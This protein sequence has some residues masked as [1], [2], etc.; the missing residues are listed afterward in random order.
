MPEPVVELQ[1]ENH[2]ARITLNRPEVHNAVDVRV[3][4]T[5]EANLEVIEADESV[6]AIILSGGGSTTFCAGGDL[7]YFATLNTREAC[8]EM[9]RRMQSILERLFYGGRPVI[10]AVNGNALGGGCEILTACHIRIAAAHA[11]FSF[12]QAPNGIITGWGGG[13]R[14]FHQ[15]GRAAALRLFLSG[16][17]INAAE[18]LRVGLIDEVVAP[19]ALP[20]ACRDLALRI[21]ANS[22]DAVK[23][24]LELAQQMELNDRRA[25]AD[26]ETE[27]FADLW[28][29]PDFRGFV[30]RF[31]L[32]G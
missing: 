1:I 20:D 2:I 28:M 27:L 22:R 21:A 19:Q 26:A 15:I 32:R 24:F 12:R 5:L 31:L 6:R 7:R 10:A 16:D 18:A 13:R 17:T 8:R 9:S 3:M 11:K 23:G 30:N 25:M 4:E 14:L 29:G